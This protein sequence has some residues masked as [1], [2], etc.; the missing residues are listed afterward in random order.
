VGS[1][2]TI[3]ITVKIV[4]VKCTIRVKN[5]DKPKVRKY[6]KFIAET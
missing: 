6:E 2:I 3:N 4:I 5:I 1:Y